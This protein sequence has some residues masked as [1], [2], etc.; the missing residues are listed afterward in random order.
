VVCLLLLFVFLLGGLYIFFGSI[1]PFG[2]TEA[3]K[4]MKP[5]PRLQCKYQTGLLLNLRVEDN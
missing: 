3:Q 4:A 5:F 2:V 1:S